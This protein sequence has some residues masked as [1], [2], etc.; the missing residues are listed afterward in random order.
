[1]SKLQSPNSAAAPRGPLAEAVIYV[2]RKLASRQ[3]ELNS[4]V[5]RLGGSYKWRYDPAQV[6]HVI[7]EGSAGDAQQ[8]EELR[9]AR[10]DKKLVVHPA[11]VQACLEQ[12]A[13]LSEELY[14]PEMRPEM[15]LEMTA[16]QVSSGHN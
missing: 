14:P 15:R 1:M 11:W 10:R 16:S 13:R 9:E 8:R 6:T 4:L 3:I 5:Q 2:A 12:G 7:F